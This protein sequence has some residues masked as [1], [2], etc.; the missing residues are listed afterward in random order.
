[1]NVVLD[2]RALAESG[3]KLTVTARFHNVPVDTAVRI[4]SNMADLQM[5]R[6]D[7]V[8]YITTPKRAAQ[9]QAEIKPK[10]EDGDI[11]PRTMPSPRQFGAPKEGGA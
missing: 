11:P 6:L 2:P 10:V 9:L 4:L 3:E 7:N 8:L 5:V 1:M